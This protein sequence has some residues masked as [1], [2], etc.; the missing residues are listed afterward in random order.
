MYWWEV[1]GRRPGEPPEWNRELFTLPD[2]DDWFEPYL[3]T[4]EQSIDQWIEEH[5]T[6]YVDLRKR[7]VEIIPR[8]EM[9]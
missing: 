9:W 5:K 1:W 3:P 8:R 6:E 7:R 4:P 2:P